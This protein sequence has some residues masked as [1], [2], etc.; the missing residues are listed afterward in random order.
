MAAVALAAVLLSPLPG[1]GAAEL[2]ASPA[3]FHTCAL[4][5]LKQSPYFSRSA[6]EIEVK[7]LDEKDSKSDYLPTINLRARYYV[8]QPS[9]ARLVNPTDYFLDFSIDSYNPLVAHYHVKVRQLLKEA[10]VVSHLLV[11]SE[12]LRQ[13]GNGF[14]ELAALARL[15]EV[16]ER[17]LE[18][19]G[20]QQTYWQRRLELGEDSAL[21]VK[22][23]VQEGE[24]AK[25]EKARILAA[26]RRLRE[27]LRD[28]LGLKP[29]EPLDFDPRQGRPQVLGLGQSVEW[30]E[31]EPRS[32]EARLEAI[33]KE[34]QSWNVTLSKLRLLPGVTA[35][36]QTPDP[37]AL[38]GVRGYFFSVGL[39]WPVFDGFKRL[40]DITRQKTLLAQAEAESLVKE[41][42]FR[43]RWREALDRLTAAAAARDLARQQVELARLKERQAELRHEGGEP[44]D[45][46]LAARRSRLE[47]EVQLT[48]KELEHDQA[49]LEVRHLSGELVKP[50]VSEKKWLP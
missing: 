26:Q 6:L 21:E 48:H 33:R 34:L 4:L 44:L 19:L 29:G 49:L 47:A 10:A 45:P 3:D 24:V 7:R 12:G 27:R 16:Q 41:T 36:V 13:L 31:Q 2:P 28:F 35:A 23:A 32:L 22:I 25:A 17:L 40:R 39:T 46:V 50:Y 15:A 37:V 1:A 43:G 20:R 18:V 9:R 5:A 30:R 42:D 14:L 38:T 11:I 8:S